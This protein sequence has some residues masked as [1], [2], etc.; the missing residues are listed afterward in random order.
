MLAFEIN[1]VPFLLLNHRVNLL[2]L[3]HRVT[4][5]LLPTEKPSVLWM[6]GGAGGSCNYRNI[7]HGEAHTN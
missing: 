6:L 7:H 3:A 4:L 1:A 5:L 2:G